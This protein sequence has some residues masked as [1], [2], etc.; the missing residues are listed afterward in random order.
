MTIVRCK[1][2]EHQPAM[3]NFGPLVNLEYSSESDMS[4]EEARVF[5][6]GGSLLLK[7]ESPSGILTIPTV[8]ETA[9]SFTGHPVMLAS[10]GEGFDVS[11]VPEG[12]TAWIERLR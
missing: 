6:K 8:V 12:C 4:W 9:N 1:I 11:L 3:P 10:L 7:V 2:R 5:L